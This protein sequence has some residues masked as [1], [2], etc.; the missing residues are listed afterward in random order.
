[1]GT[2]PAGELTKQKLYEV[3]KEVFYEKG[4]I[5]ATLKEICLRAGV[6]Q[7]VFFYHYK[8]KNEIAKLI[9]TKYGEK[10]TGMINDEVRQNAYTTDLINYTCICSAVFYYNTLEDPN[11]NRFWAEMY[12]NNMPLDIPFF[13]HRYRNMY[14]KRKLDANSLDFDFYLISST[15]VDG[16]LLQKYYNKDFDATPDQLVRFKLSNMLW[17]LK[18]EQKEIDERIDKIMEIAKKITV[19][20]GK[21]FEIFYSRDNIEN[22]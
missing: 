18:F 4:Y 3:A 16:V 21:N 20:S 8:D 17:G 12:L 6:K 7:S 1:M 14:I 15:S 2:Y 10:S 22:I 9:Y 13:R 5:N 19:H 11:L